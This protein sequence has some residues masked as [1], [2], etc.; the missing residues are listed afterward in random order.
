MLGE[1]SALSPYE[2]ASV[3]MKPLPE[4]AGVRLQVSRR[5]ADVAGSSWNPAGDV[6]V[7]VRSNCP[8]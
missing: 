6:G 3:W 4:R 8:L 5:K 2:A 1:N 7:G